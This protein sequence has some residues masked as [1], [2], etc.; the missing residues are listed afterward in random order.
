LKDYQRHFATALFEEM[1]LLLLADAH[2]YHNTFSQIVKDDHPTHQHQN[3]MRSRGLKVYFNIELRNESSQTFKSAPPRK[4]LYLPERSREH[5]SSYA[6]DDL[7]IISSNA[8][9]VPRN[10]DDLFFFA[11]SVFHG[12]SSRDGMLEVRAKDIENDTIDILELMLVIY[13]SKQSTQTRRFDCE[14]VR[15]SMRFVGLM[16]ALN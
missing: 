15:P 9:F 4:C 13:R 12:P 1:N 7:W 10:A 16:L 8:S 3:Q 14:R 2:K 5:H 6:K 11:R